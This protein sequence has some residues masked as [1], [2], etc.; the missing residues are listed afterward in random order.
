MTVLS[1]N[2]YP[3][4]A[5]ITITLNSLASAG[6]RQSTAIDNTS[7]LYIDAIL[8]VSATLVAGTP[9]NGINV[10][11]AGSEDG[12]LWPDGLGATD[13]AYTMRS[14]TNLALV[15]PIW[16]ATAGGLVWTMQPTGIAQF[17]GGVM[18]RKWLIVVQN[19]SGLAFAG[20]GCSASYTGI[21][22][23]NV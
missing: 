17:F 22:Y 19:S 12:T 11:V 7:N 21:E 23:Q 13:A 4:S 2:T 8:N 1:L 14:P 6:V 10:Y 18:P 5:A 20:S 9:S 3:A 16:T 15:R